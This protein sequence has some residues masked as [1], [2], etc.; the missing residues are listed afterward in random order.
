M[1]EIADWLNV[2]NGTIELPAALVLVEMTA[3]VADGPAELVPK[4]VTPL[5]GAV[6]NYLELYLAHYLPQ[7]FRSSP[8]RLCS[9]SSDRSYSSHLYRCRNWCW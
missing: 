6:A 7:L 8:R 4:M 9:P 3:P 5:V 2:V 1:V